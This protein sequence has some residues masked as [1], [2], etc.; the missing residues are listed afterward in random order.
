MSQN[1][2]QEIPLVFDCEGDD[3][4][5]VVHKPAQPA[6]V[7]V[8]S[9]I[10]GGP[11]YRGGVGRGM[12]SM[13]RDLAA[14]GVAVLRFDYRGMGDSAGDFRGFEDIAADLQAAVDALRAAVPEVTKVVLWGGCDAASGVMIHGWKI[15][16]AVSLVLG[17][18]WVYTPQIESAVRRQ[19]YLSRLTDWSFWRKLL[20]SEY[21]LLGYVRSAMAKVLQ[22]VVGVFSSATQETGNDGLSAAS[23]V[24]RMLGGLQRYEGSVLFLI[25][26]Q[27][28]ASKEF[29]E[30]IASDSGWRAVS[31]RAGYERVDFP[32]ADQTFSTAEA[33]EGVS[34]AIALW[35]EKL[36]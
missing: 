16:D 34:K 13:A 21:N 14:N 5:G 31:E 3:L 11:Q 10:A 20:R 18:P 28:I 22:R 24:D 30:L 19:H 6:Q 32:E 35:L 27:S 15:P 1:D 26:G 33:R 23:F 36:R 7:G 29:D 25:S 2:V 9:I 8:I 12:V 4:L 17:N